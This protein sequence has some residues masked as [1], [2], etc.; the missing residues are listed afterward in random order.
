MPVYLVKEHH[1]RLPSHWRTITI[2]HPSHT[3]T[4]LQH[5]P[6]PVNVH[7]ISRWRSSPCVLLCYQPFT[8][9]LLWWGTGP[10]QGLSHHHCNIW[11]MTGPHTAHTICC[12]LKGYFANF[13][14]YV[15]KP[16]DVYCIT[17][18]SCSSLAF[19]WAMMVKELQYRESSAA[20]ICFLL[21]STAQLRES[22]TTS[23][24]VR[25]TSQQGLQCN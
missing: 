4:G 11:K 3:H 24:S 1:L 12:V 13:P 19:T 14:P 20:E 17:V 8:E 5:I 10:G 21:S 2:T 18:T 7:F 25:V 9:W 15:V 6:W 22:R 23:Q 16:A